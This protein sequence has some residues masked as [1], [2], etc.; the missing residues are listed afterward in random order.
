MKKRWALAIEWL[1]ESLHP[2]DSYATTTAMMIRRDA[3]ID[4]L[5][6]REGELAQTGHGIPKS[7]REVMVF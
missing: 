5:W 7:E 3:S 4:R 2:P 1:A 6:H